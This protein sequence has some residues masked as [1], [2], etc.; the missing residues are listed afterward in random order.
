MAASDEQ[1][2]G[3]H[4]ESTSFDPLKRFELDRLIRYGY[5][6]FLLTGILL[7]I[8]P[9]SVHPLVE[10]GGA[11]V[12]PL[13]ILATGAAVY[14]LY[15]YVLSEMLLA[16]WL[17]RWHGYLDRRH[18]VITNPANFLVDVYHVPANLGHDAYMEVRR[19]F[20]RDEKFSFDRNHT[21]ATIVW[22][23][24]VECTIA[25]G[26]LLAMGANG[27]AVW[28]SWFLLSVGLSNIAAAV[29]LDLR[30]FRQEYRV[31]AAYDATQVL[32]FLRKRGLVGAPKAAAQGA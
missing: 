14:T 3:R 25:G 17:H 19:G 30:L 11:V 28:K 13:V 23:T 18:Q 1:S 24:A 27:G 4:E 2:N 21:E 15:R 20:F 32:E 29:N 7:F 8:T 5:S 10:A 6:G 31:L 22:L 26:V 9:T 16:R 12:T